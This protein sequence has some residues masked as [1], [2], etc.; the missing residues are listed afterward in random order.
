MSLLP[1][2]LAAG[3]GDLG[4]AEGA[5]DVLAWTLIVAAVQVPTA[6]ANVTVQAYLGRAG[7][8][9]PGSVGRRASVVGIF[10]FVFYNQLFVLMTV[11]ACFWMDMVPWFGSSASFDEVRT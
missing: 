10:R 11:A 7:A 6:M 5:V 3:G 1:A 2:L 9:L 4:G 8:H